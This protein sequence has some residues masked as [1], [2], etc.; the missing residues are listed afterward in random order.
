MQIIAIHHWPEGQDFIQ[1]IAENLDLLVFEAQQ[2]M[3]GG[4]PVIIA[5]FADAAVAEAAKNRLEEIG[6]PCL[7]IDT[8][9]LQE[10]SEP[11]MVRHFRLADTML[12]IETASGQEINIPY[13]SMTHLLSATTVIT[14]EE[15]G[16]TETRRKFSLGKTMLAG[17]VPMSK[18]VAQQ[19]VGK[20]EQR[21]EIL[22]LYAGVSS[23]FYFMRNRLNYSGLGDAMKITGELNFNF[24]KAELARLAPQALADDRLRNRSGLVR[25]LGTSFDPDT[26]LDLAFE[27]LVRSLQPSGSE[28]KKPK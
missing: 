19:T 20:Q 11:V 27:V 15:Q 26:H 16:T 23:P 18:K 9:E 6:T 14:P 24:L 21:D 1:K 28:P 8:T 7:L 3:A 12:E 2:R 10:K 5:S 13:S 4:G 25:L 22:C 17:G